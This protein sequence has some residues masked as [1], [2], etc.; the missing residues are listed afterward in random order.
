MGKGSL[1]Y[2]MNVCKYESSI[3]GMTAITCRTHGRLRPFLITSWISA[4]VR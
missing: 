2:F 4:A 1:P 3:V